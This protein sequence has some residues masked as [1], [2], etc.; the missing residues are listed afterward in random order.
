MIINGEH[1]DSYEDWCEETLKYMQC[2]K[3]SFDFGNGELTMSESGGEHATYKFSILHYLNSFHEDNEFQKWLKNQRQNEFNLKVESKFNEL[4]DERIVRKLNN[5]YDI[6]LQHLN[7]RKDDIRFRRFS[8]WGWRYPY[9]LKRDENGTE[10]V[11]YINKTEKR[12]R[13]NW[14]SKRRKKQSTRSYQHYCEYCERAI[15][16]NDETIC[17]SCYSNFEA[18]GIFVFNYWKELNIMINNDN[19]VEYQVSNG[20][21]FF[22]DLK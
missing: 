2:Q 15:V 13:K 6:N 11:S 14:S 16:Y 9:Y 4:S 7:K 8:G 18:E 19:F 1:Y 3:E 20:K 12:H 5:R 17:D 22:H 10:Y 21:W